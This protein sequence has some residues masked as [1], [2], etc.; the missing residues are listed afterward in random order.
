[1]LEKFKKDELELKGF[2]EKMYLD[3][4]KVI[5]DNDYISQVKLT[6]ECGKETNKYCSIHIKNVERYNKFTFRVKIR[7]WDDSNM[8]QKEFI[9]NSNEEQN[10]VSYDEMKKFICE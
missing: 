7:I 9:F 4:K 10:K 3:T 2:I 6:F 1:M 8:K 5:D